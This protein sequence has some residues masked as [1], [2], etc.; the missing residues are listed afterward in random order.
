MKTIDGIK[1]RHE[2]RKASWQNYGALHPLDHGPVIDDTDDLFAEIERLRGK[3]AVKDEHV[4]LFRSERDEACVHL[5]KQNARVAEL[6]AALEL[7]VDQQNG[8]PLPSYE[9][10]WNRAM[11][12]AR[13]ALAKG[14]A[15]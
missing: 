12:M 7:L 10:E 14:G 15:P 9:A 8:C 2:T 13:L 3:L 1:A 4:S 5:V 11:K 6:E